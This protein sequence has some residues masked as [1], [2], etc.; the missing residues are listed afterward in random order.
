[1]RMGSIHLGWQSTLG[2][3]SIG[4]SLVLCFTASLAP[5]GIPYSSVPYF[6]LGLQ[7][8]GVIVPTLCRSPCADFSSVCLLLPESGG[9]QTS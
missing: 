5:P 6:I 4:F 1:M 3:P 9:S 2:I 8:Q 7:S